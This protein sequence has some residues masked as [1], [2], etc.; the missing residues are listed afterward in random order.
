M[1]GWDFALA[2][3]AAMYSSAPERGHIISCILFDI[4]KPT[5]EMQNLKELFIAH[6][7]NVY[8][9]TEMLMIPNGLHGSNA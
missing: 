6:Y 3:F 4:T 1:A 7:T 9:K 5:R 2:L 8:I